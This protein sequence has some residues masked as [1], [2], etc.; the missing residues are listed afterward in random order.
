[1]GNENTTNKDSHD[2]AANIKTAFFLN[3]GFTLIEVVGGLLSN[4]IAILSDALH[5]FGD[6]I[7]LG[8][9]WY[10]QR[11]SKKGETSAYTY[12][13]HRF[14]TF[15]ALITSLVLIGGIA[16][17]LWQAIQRVL[18]PEEVNAPVMIGLSVLG[19]VMNGVAVLKLKGG[20]SLNERVVGWH[21]LE[22]TLGWIAVLI[23]SV[24]MAFWN[25]PIVDPLLSIGISLFVLWNVLKELKD[26]FRVFLQ[27]TPE[28]FDLEEFERDVQ[29]LPRILSYHHMHSWS[30]DGERHVLSLH[31]VM[32]KNTT[33]EQI[34]TVKQRIQELL[35]DKAFEHIAID[36][37]FEGELCV[38]AA[39][40]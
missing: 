13:Y 16:F 7:S 31:L 14:S 8:V 1:M 27:R 24:V 30:L 9:S 39:Q 11:L 25:V 35:K 33:R 19:I 40:S 18:S 36:V 37:E 15:G 10:M 38:T 12:G 26:V 5:D 3:L 20:H 22:D 2:A 29:R 4:S 32:Q 17:V 23:G 34:V 6:C 21:L 28:H